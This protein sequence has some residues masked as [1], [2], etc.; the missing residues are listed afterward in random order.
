MRKR[1]LFFVALGAWLLLV[2]WTG[3]PAVA[4]EPPP[5][6]N[7]RGDNVWYM[8]TSTAVHSDISPPLREIK[9]VLGGPYKTDKDDPGPLTPCGPIDGIDPVAQ[10][11]TG[12][13][14]NA[15]PAPNVSFDAWANL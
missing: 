14:P 10:L 9:P 13:A 8:G 11:S 12:E 3:A 7:Y 4:Q 5:A 15:M 6:D 1:E 2:V